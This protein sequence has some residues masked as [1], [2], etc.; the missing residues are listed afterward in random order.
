MECSVFD[1]VGPSAGRRYITV[2]RMEDFGK[3]NYGNAPRHIP[4]SLAFSPSSSALSFF[5]PTSLSEVLFYVQ[6]KI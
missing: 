2:R 3:Q 4:S 6:M 1:V 5:F